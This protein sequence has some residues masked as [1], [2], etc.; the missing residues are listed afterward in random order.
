ME[1]QTCTD[2]TTLVAEK[3]AS[4]TYTFREIT[5]ADELEMAFRLR[6]EVYSNTGNKV[7]LHQNIHKIDIDVFD[8]HSKHFGI[9]TDQGKLVAY[10]R[11]VLDKSEIKNDLV[12]DI[13]QKFELDLNC[14]KNRVDY[15]FL[16]YP[17]VPE[18]VKSHYNDLKSK[19]EGLAEA[20]RLIIREEFRGARLSSFLI[21]CAMVLFTLI[22]NERKHAVVCCDKHHSIF[23]ERY[24][25][26]SFGNSEVYDVFGI[27]RVTLLLT[28]GSATS[29]HVIERFA[30]IAAE[31]SI[32]GQITRTI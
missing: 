32:T 3:K 12:S 24:G 18:C 19:K 1:P 15:P 20:S 13:V 11:V 4:T 16:S 2:P 31:Y 17:T 29:K 8:A 10:I 9:F 25:F 7:F 6:Y 26:T 27:T 28:L 14:A 23:Y 21:E 5:E 30:G 22:C